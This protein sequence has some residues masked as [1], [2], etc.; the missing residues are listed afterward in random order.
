MSGAPPVA[1]HASSAQA[2]L[3]LPAS[4]PFTPV[5]LASRAVLEPAFRGSGYRLCEY[6]FATQV[7]WHD[8]NT[9]EWAIRDGWMYLRY[10]EAGA[11]RFVCPIGKGEPSPAVEACFRHLEERGHPPVVRFVPGQVA[12]A[13]DPA[14]FRLSPDPDNDDY[15]YGVQQLAELAGRRYSKKRN[16]I[17]Q[18]LRGGAWSFDPVLPQD[19]PAIDAF[20]DAWCRDRECVGDPALDYAYTHGVTVGCAAGAGSEATQ[21]VAFLASNTATACG[22]CAATLRRYSTV[23][24][25]SR[26]GIK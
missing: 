5:D 16:H 10:R 26:N 18:F 13:L 6:S 21:T 12:S 25:G 20:L 8:F 7:C 22:F 19:R 14:R 23:S 17:A 1:S 3:R 4:T 9:S 15:V 24:Y 2:P 11:E